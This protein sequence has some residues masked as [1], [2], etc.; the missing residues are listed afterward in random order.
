MT[1]WLLPFTFQLVL[2]SIVVALL[3]LPLWRKPSFREG[4]LVVQWRDWFDDR[5]RFSTCVAYV[6]GA[7]RDDIDRGA[8]W[9]HEVNVHVKQYED[10]AVLSTIIAGAIYAFVPWQ[11]SLVV[12]ATG[13]PLWILPS[14]LTALR[15]RKAG[16]KLGWKP[17]ETMYRMSEP[18][19]SAYAQEEIFVRNGGGR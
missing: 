17:W 18:E 1:Y 14:Y 13:G 11:V 10:M 16:K 7:G 6:M 5:W 2:Q 8:T 12:W 3:S 4:I 9:F 19:R 15:F